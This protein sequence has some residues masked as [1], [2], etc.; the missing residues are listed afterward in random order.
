[1]VGSILALG[2]APRSV[3]DLADDPLHTLLEPLPGLGRRRLDEP[4][5]VPDG[6]EVQPLGDLQT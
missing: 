3:V 1:M 5:A 6:V 2:A 4:R